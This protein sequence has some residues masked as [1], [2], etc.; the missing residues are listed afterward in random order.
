MKIS[1]QRLVELINEELEK[2][3]QE[4]LNEY[5]AY[6]AISSGVGD[7]PALRNSTHPDPV[8]DLKSLEVGQLDDIATTGL[9]GLFNNVQIASR[10]IEDLP[11]EEI[12]NSNIADMLVDAAELIRAALDNIAMEREREE[13]GYI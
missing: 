6:T 10:I 1:K 12:S 7:N 2:D 8:N 9:D 11:F 13:K 3:A 4:V 5:G